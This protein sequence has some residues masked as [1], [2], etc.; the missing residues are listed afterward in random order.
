MLLSGVTCYFFNPIQLLRL[1][2]RL[3]KFAQKESSSF[4]KWI[5]QIAFNATQVELACTLAGVGPA[6]PQR[7]CPDTLNP[8]G[9]IEWIRR[10]R[11]GVSGPAW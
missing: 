3:N 10:C 6:T 4:T 8:Y 7:I 11:S 2:M 9:S 1:D 5:W